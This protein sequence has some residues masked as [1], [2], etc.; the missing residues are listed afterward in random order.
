MLDAECHW[1]GTNLIGREHPGGLGRHVGD[2]KREV[3]FLALVAAFSCANGFDITKASG[4]PE[5]KRG[6]D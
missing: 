4:R 1:S 5:A 6:G 2:D 3:P